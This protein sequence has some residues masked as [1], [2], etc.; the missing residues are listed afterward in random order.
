MDFRYSANVTKGSTGSDTFYEVTGDDP[1]NMGTITPLFNATGVARASGEMI[2]INSGIAISLVDKQNQG[3]HPY[4][5]R[6]NNTEDHRLA[7][8]GLSGPDTFVGWGWLNHSGQSHIYASD[9]L[10]TGSRIA[11]PLPAAIC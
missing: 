4:S 3:K 2:Q 7:G 1:S 8:Y 6:F 10:F 9:W 11:A 5:F